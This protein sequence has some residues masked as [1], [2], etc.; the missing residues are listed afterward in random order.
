MGTHERA[1][2]K[3][4]RA[5][6]SRLPAVS[7]V[8]GNRIF[9]A[10]EFRER[11]LRDYMAGGSPV[12]I[13]RRAGMGPELIGYKRIERAFARWRQ[14]RAPARNRTTDSRT[15]PARTPEPTDTGDMDPRDRLIASQALTIARLQQQ[16]NQQQHG[17]TATPRDPAQRGTDDP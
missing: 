9:Y 14:G 13:F 6:L 8:R 4:T 15:R 11:A 3:A 1:F 5:Y 7:R 2:D 10:E 12:E 17:Q 16:L